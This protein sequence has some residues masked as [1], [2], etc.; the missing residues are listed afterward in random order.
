MKNIMLMQ[1]EISLLRLENKELRAGIAAGNTS[2]YG[3][4]NM[5]QTAKRLAG[6]LRHAA[7]SAE[8]SLR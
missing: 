5:N 1:T 8:V 4:S 6:D 3:S 7:S 2:E